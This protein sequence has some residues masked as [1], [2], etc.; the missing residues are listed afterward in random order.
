MRAGFSILWRG[1]LRHIL[2]TPHWSAHLEG[3]YRPRC[4]S[5]QGEDVH[6]ALSGITSTGYLQK[7]SKDTAITGSHSTKTTLTSMTVQAEKENNKGREQLSV[8][9]PLSTTPSPLCFHFQCREPHGENFKRQKMLSLPVY[10]NAFQ[11]C[12]VIPVNFT[13]TAKLKS[14]ISYKI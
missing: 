1:G 9:L 2:Q 12:Y 7:Q 10:F 8:F 3:F 14:H 5:V 13:V 11:P 6:L 4:G